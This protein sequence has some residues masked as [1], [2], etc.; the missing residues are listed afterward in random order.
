MLFLYLIF[1]FIFFRTGYATNVIFAV[2]LFWNHRTVT[3]SSEQKSL[4]K[5][6]HCFTALLVCVVVVLM[7]LVEMTTDVSW[8]AMVV[9]DAIW[10][11]F[12]TAALC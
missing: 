3:M 5:H 2:C 9:I 8:L 4:N 11:A 7:T 6:V 10:A 12:S 1:T